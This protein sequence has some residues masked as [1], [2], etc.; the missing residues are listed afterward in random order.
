MT[1]SAV[2]QAAGPVAR[3]AWEAS[4]PVLGNLAKYGAY[5][6]GGLLGLGGLVAAAPPLFRAA[7]QAG[8]LVPP[9]TGEVGTTTQ[10]SPQ[11]ANQQPVSQQTFEDQIKIL[12]DLIN[13]QS[14]Q[15][16]ALSQ[17]EIDQRGRV[18]D[19][20]TNP[21]Y[22]AQR[23]AVDQANWERRQELSRIAGMDQTRELTRRKIEGDII[24]AWQNI[25]SEQIKAQ[26]QI[27]SNMMNL[28]Y[29]SSV[30][31]PNVLNAG[32][33]LAAQGS[34]GFSAPTSTLR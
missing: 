30:P 12:T 6:L 22:Y 29:A 19:A 24:N 26:A 5:G 21:E 3:G 14:Q 34:R 10:S 23:A 8:G 17:A 32:A 1:Y 13:A 27:S 16:T 7:T 33:Q 28:A 15:S 31:N 11:P 25:T 2:K 4:A 18:I 9:T 20:L